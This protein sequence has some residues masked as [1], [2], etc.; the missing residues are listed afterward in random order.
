MSEK[1]NTFGDYEFEDWVPEKLREHIRDFWGQMGRTSDDWIRDM[2]NGVSD[3]CYYIPQQG[4]KTPP[5]GARVIYLI[6]DY[7]AE[8]R[9]GRSER[10]YRAIEGRYIHAWN[11]MGRVVHEDGTYTVVSSCDKWVRVFKDKMEAEIA[12]A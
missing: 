2:C 4:F 10:L 3:V 1:I 7:D 12:L 11:N 8:K 5:T 9:A 6:K